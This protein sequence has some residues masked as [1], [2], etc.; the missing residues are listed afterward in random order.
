MAKLLSINGNFPVTKPLP[1]VFSIYVTRE[2][3]SVYSNVQSVCYTNA[4]KNYLINNHI[5]SSYNLRASNSD[6][7]IT[8]N[9]TLLEDYYA[10]NSV[11][12]PLDHAGF[13]EALTFTKEF[14]VT[15]PINT[16]HLLVESDG[17]VICGIQSVIPFA[18]KTGD[19]VKINIELNHP[20]QPTEIVGTGTYT[21]DVGEG[22][23]ILQHNLA[24]ENIIPGNKIL[25]LHSTDE[26]T[27][28]PAIIT[29]YPSSNNATKKFR[30]NCQMPKDYLLAGL[31]VLNY[32]E[33]TTNAV[34]LSFDLPI[35]ISDGEADEV[36]ISF[37]IDLLWN[38]E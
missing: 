16:K 36:S 13:S 24:A 21:S 17:V 25:L 18:I 3:K 15:N 10:P 9:L 33:D 7:T 8:P 6:I 4:I 26:A 27:E 34:E 5:F 20:E 30:I 31:R 19:F 35:H 37:T 12:V 29:E 2:G 28:V 1:G 11:L 38:W 14:T 23:C 22:S 32:A